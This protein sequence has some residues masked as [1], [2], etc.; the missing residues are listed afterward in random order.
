MTPLSALW[1]PIVVSALAVFVASSLIH[2]VLPWHKNDYPRLG[3]ERQV[4]DAL[5][6]L[7]VPPGDYM[8]PRPESRA[9]LRAPEFLERMKAGPVVIMTVLPNGPMAMGSTL[10][11]WL[12]YLLILATLT[13]LVTALAVRPGGDLHE[14]IHI[15]AIVSF[16]GYTMALWQMSI[17]YRRSWS[18]TLKATVDGLIYAA[19][20]AAIFAW[21]WPR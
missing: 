16:A 10:V 13:A 20:T 19:I 6:P 12:V 14:V 21:L 11:L 3:N 9:E 7:G 18:T 4:L 17:W 8:M 1:L 2:M 5:R 15:S